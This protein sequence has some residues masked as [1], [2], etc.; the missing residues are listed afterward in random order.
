MKTAVTR[1]QAVNAS[2]VD[3]RASPRAARAGA[4]RDTALQAVARNFAM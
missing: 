4:A 2:D 3:Q 1:P